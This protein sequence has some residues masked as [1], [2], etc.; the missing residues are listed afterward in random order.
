MSFVLV[1][2][3]LDG[4]LSHTKCVINGWPLTNLLLRRLWII[5][6]AQFT[7]VK[8]TELTH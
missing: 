7:D 4:L 6:I 5:I 8:S 2:N 1:L 3:W